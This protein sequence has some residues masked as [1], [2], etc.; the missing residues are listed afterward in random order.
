MGERLIY[1]EVRYPHVACAPSISSFTRRDVFLAKPVDSSQLCDWHVDDLGFWPAQFVSSASA[2]SG[3][4]Q[5]GI[6]VWLSLDDMPAKYEGSMAVAP[7]SHAA[8]SRWRAEAY[9][10][11]GQN[12]SEDVPVTIESFASMITNTCVMD[13]TRP[14]FR[15][16]LEASKLVFDL[17]RGDAIFATRLLFHRV[18]EVTP[19]G[20]EYYGSL[21]KP[22]LNRYSIRYVPGT[23]Q[24][25]KG[26]HLL[27]WSLLSNP[28]NMG[29]AL[30]DVADHDGGTLWFPKVWPTLDRK[31]DDRLDA[32]GTDKVPAAKE[33]ALAESQSL[34]KA[35][36]AMREQK[37]KNK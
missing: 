16:E 9:S 6:N 35:L 20:R 36:Q 33:K 5:D 4:D 15:A 3:T 12:R 18:T 13:Q 11:I 32:V 27:E 8:D 34:G 1:L 14:D 29:L 17:E 31:I 26:H 25:P 23:T 30:D 24:L 10:A 2:S 28:G 21:G 7:G 22:T 37:E 19:E